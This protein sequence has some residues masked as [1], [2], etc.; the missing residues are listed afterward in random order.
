MKLSVVSQADPRKGLTGLVAQLNKVKYFGPDDISSNREQATVTV[1]SG[2]ATHSTS[3]LIAT[4][5]FGPFC[6]CNVVASGTVSVNVLIFYVQL[7]VKPKLSRGATSFQSLSYSLD[8][9]VVAGAISPNPAHAVISIPVGS[10]IGRLE[11]NAPNWGFWGPGIY[12]FAGSFVY[13][14]E[15]TV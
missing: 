6:F 1:S 10:E 15:P 5:Q 4:T 11:V 7:P 14:V 9:A 8:F 2:A 12:A 13:P 3:S